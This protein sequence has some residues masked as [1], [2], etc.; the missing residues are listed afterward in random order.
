MSVYWK[1]ENENENGNRNE[2]KMEL[3]RDFVCVEN[4]LDR[5]HTILLCMLQTYAYQA[6]ALYVLSAKRL[7]R[8]H[9]S[10]KPLS[11]EL[12]NILI[13]IFFWPIFRLFFLL[14]NQ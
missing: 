4:S 8:E 11:M 1:N 3:F 7:R 9:K 10:S 5:S 6:I 12:H 2:L 14:I 13:G